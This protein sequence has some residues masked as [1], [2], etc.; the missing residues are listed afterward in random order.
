MKRILA[1]ALAA[2]MILSSVSLVFAGGLYDETYLRVY[3][4]T[5]LFSDKDLS[6]LQAYSASCAELYGLDFVLACIEE[7]SYD[8]SYTMDDFAAELYEA[9]LY[10]YGKD[11]DGAV[12]VY[13]PA[14]REVHVKLFGRAQRLIDEDYV[15]YIE[16]HAYS[17]FYE[18]FGDWGVL[19][20]PLGMIAAECR[21]NEVTPDSDG[22]LAK[23]TDTKEAPVM[24]RPGSEAAAQEPAPQPE[25]EAPAVAEPASQPA[26]DPAADPAQ[27]AVS[28]E[29][30]PDWY[31]KDMSKFSFFN[32]PDAPRVVDDA[33]I[34]SDD[35]EKAIAERIALLTDHCGKDAVIY[36]NTS[37]WGKSRMEV[38]D[39]FYDYNGYGI[40]GDREGCCLYVCMDPDTRGFWVSQTGPDAMSLYTESIANTMDDV[41]YYAFK[42]AVGG[43]EGAFAEGILDWLDTVETLYTK[44]IPYAPAWYPDRN[45]TA[46]RASRF[47]AQQPYFT[48]H[49]CDDAGILT[50]EERA[51]YEAQAQQLSDQYGLDVVLH[52][53]DSYFEMGAYEYAEAFYEY[54]GLGLGAE[55]KG[56]LLTVFS[57]G[58][59]HSAVHYEGISG[60]LMTTVNENRLMNKA[61]D[62]TIESPQAGTEQFLSDLEHLLRTGRVNK[63]AFGWTVSGI[64]IAIGGG[65]YAF[66]SYMAG[67]RAMKKPHKK[68]DANEYVVKNSFRNLGGSAVF[69]YERTSTHYDPLPKDD[70]RSSGGSSGGGSSYSSSH[71]SSSGSSH[72]G[73]G[74]TF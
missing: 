13:C 11:R 7:T 57:K 27:E 19:Y 43:T 45:E 3:D 1:A 46:D 69:L 47:E 22:L 59:V 14:T 68:E 74:R 16:A 30:L 49:V 6:D 39:D 51:A 50:S 56:I 35:E 34:L 71:T 61:S 60:E 58:Y 32:D 63:S 26:T 37:T 9:G 38:A 8:D 67:L 65:I 15:A 42:R 4:E 29:E 53:A 62:K 31:P 17:D 54:N 23:A 66:F 21:D 40:G 72:S 36:T 10:G 5:G 55:R 52:Y 44:G 48:G 33:D 12:A 2:F 73:S 28:S 70:G 20:Y 41:L 24:T 25:P 18:K 64:L